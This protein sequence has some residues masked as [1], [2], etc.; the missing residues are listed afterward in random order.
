[1]TFGC[2]SL[3]PPVGSGGLILV[4]C[5]P[6]IWFSL[7]GPGP[8]W[9]W[10]RG[11]P[12]DGGKFAP[13]GL[14]LRC[15]MAFRLLSNAVESLSVR[16]RREGFPAFVIQR[17]PTGAKHSQADGHRLRGFRLRLANWQRWTFGKGHAPVCAPLPHSFTFVRGARGERGRSRCRDALV[18]RLR[19]CIARRGGA[20]AR[21]TLA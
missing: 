10:F 18:C 15:Q 4:G 6:G 7:W 19:C 17:Q 1:L 5:Q 14:S 20:P 8:G 3:M 13:G 11:V 21:S 12:A 16:G 9:A 2:L